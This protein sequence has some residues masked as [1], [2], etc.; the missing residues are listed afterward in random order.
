MTALKPVS[1][2]EKHILRNLY[3]LYLHDLSEY[4]EDLDISADGSFEF[5]AF[6]MIWER[7]G[8]TPYFINTDESIAG[9]LLLLE[10]P[11]LKNDY[12][13]CINDI[14]I[15]K[16][17]RRKGI[18]LSLIKELFGQKKGR[19]FLVELVRNTPAVTFWR[20]TLRELEIEFEEDRKDIDGEEC[21]FQAF[22]I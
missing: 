19:C 18:A 4:T 20:K 22:Q 12:D 1:T 16:K 14:F 5:D 17:F 15:L 8:L 11:F 9:F 7:E 21:F 10:R 2:E 3:S 6:E 13:L